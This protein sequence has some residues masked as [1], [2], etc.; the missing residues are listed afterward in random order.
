MSGEH[1]LHND[2]WYPLEATP[3]GECATWIVRDGMSQAVHRDA[4]G[5]RLEDGDEI[6]FARAVV[7]FSAG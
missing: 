5:T 4:R 1:R 7:R 3:G 6:H 2:R